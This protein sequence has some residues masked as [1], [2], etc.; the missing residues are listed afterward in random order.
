MEAKWLQSAINKRNGT[1]LKVG[2]LT[3]KHQALLLKKGAIYIRPTK[4]NGI[5]EAVD[6]HAS[7]I[8]DSLDR[9]FE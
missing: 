7:I 5:A 4:L 1:K 6:M 3:I 2:S 9:Y 8:S